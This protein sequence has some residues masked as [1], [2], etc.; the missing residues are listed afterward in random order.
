MERDGQESRNLYGKEK[1]A[2]YM[3]VGVLLAMGVSDKLKIT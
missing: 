3:T 2:P 1:L